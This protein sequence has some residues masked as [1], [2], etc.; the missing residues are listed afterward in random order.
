MSSRLRV[1]VASSFLLTA[2]AAHALEAGDNF[3]ALGVAGISTSLAA[4]SLNYSGNVVLPGP[5]RIPGPLPISSANASGSSTI[6]LILGHMFTD[7]F[8][9]VLDMGYPPKT[10]LYMSQPILTHGAS[11]QIASVDLW[12]PMLVGRYYFLDRSSSFRPYLG[13]GATYS[14]FQNLTLTSAG[15]S[16][17]PNGASLDSSIGWV[18]SM[19]FNYDFTGTRYF[20]TGALTYT[21]VR[22]AMHVNNLVDPAPTGP[23]ASASIRMTNAIGFFGAGCR[24]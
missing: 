16:L 21:Q 2:T 12:S 13:A 20:L 17:A 24:F 14:R 10:D 4:G 11:T 22:T 6:A 15:Q 1:A 3:A 7:H 18:A 19:G 9:L 5:T 23:A 8:A